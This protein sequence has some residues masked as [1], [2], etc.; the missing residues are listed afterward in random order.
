MTR[1]LVAAA[2]AVTRA[3]LEAIL[4]REPAFTVVGAAIGSLVE[5]VTE[6]EPDVVL[7]EL[8][9]IDDDA[10]ALLHTLGV[11]ADDGARPS[12]AIVVLSDERDPAHIG[13]LLRGG[14]RAI[15]PRD[16]G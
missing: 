2:S 9:S 8:A 14:S 11:D 16:A 3:G 5:E 15:L 12:P 6:H 4:A 1:V 10:L 7:L 13:E